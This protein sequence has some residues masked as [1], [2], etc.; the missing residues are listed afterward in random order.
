MK[1]PVD[2][3]TS[4]CGPPAGARRPAANSTSH[5]QLKPRRRL[6]HRDADAEAIA[7]GFDVLLE[8]FVEL[9]LALGQHRR[10]QR[11]IGGR[12][13][14]LLAVQVVAGRDRQH[15]LDA[16]VV[17]GARGQLEGDVRVEKVIRRMRGAPSREQHRQTRDKEAQP[18]GQEGSLAHGSEVCRSF[19]RP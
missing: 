5:E 16:A 4:R 10:P 15:H 6:L 18:E 14:E 8:G 13:L 9:D 2:A 12:E 17:D 1:P 3:G 11:R 19:E 7:I